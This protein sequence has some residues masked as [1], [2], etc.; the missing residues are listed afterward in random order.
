MARTAPEP[1]AAPTARRVDRSRSPVRAAALSLL[2]LSIYG[3]WWWYDLN[4]RLR[5]LGQPARPWRALGLVTVGLVVMAPAVMADLPW[6]AVALSPIP[7]VLSLLAVWQT[8]TLLAAAQRARAARETISVP[9]AVTLA[10]AAVVGAVT[11]YALAA[12]K[13]DAYLLVGVA[14]PLL[15][16]GFVAYLQAQL[17]AVPGDGG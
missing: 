10:G 2:T 16:M 12:L 13:V 1:P 8:A 4:R 5:A 14:W 7:V 3:F 11:W 6:L 17:N 9:T 15:A